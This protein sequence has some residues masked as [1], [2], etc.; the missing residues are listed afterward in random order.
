MD[1]EQKLFLMLLGDFLNERESVLPEAGYDWETLHLYGT[2][3]NLCGIV[4]EQL[5]HVLPEPFLSRFRSDY[6]AELVRCRHRKSVTGEMTAVLEEN[7]MEFFYVKGDVVGRLYTNPV[8]RSMSDVDV[9][10]RREALPMLHERL[11]E[12]GFECTEQG[13]SVWSYRKEGVAFEVHS[14]LI[15]SAHRED[16]AVAQAMGRCWEHVRDGELD[17]S[18]HM[19]YLLLHLRKHFR[20]RGVG[21]RQFL[22]IAFVAKRCALDWVQIRRELEELGLWNFALKVFGLCEHWFD[23]SVFPQ[24]TEPDEVFFQQA[25]EFIIQNGVFG[26]G[27]EENKDNEIVNTGRSEGL[28]G[29]LLHALAVLFPGYRDMCETERYSFLAGK[30]VLLPLAWV[31]RIVYLIREGKLR[32]VFS[33]LSQLKGKARKRREIYAQWEL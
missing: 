33:G 6:L 8:L 26:Y 24:R 17:W 21:F 10:V 20:V 29:L 7:G 23:C 16:D 13:I 31:Y 32:E 5:R 18:F 9:M 28:F 2:K 30:P 14:A 1:R 12:T 15:R 3:H 4:Y 11:L 19:L 25:T 27:N 22:D